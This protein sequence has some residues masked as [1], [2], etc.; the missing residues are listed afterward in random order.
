MVG[1]VVS[2]SSQAGVTI[3][4]GGLYASGQK[5]K[6]V[7]AYWEEGDEVCTIISNTSSTLYFTSG[8]SSAPD[9]GD[10]IMVGRIYSQLK[11]QEYR[12]GKQTEYQQDLLL[13][14]DFSAL[15]SAKTLIVKMYKD[16]SDTASTWTAFT[17]VAGVTFQS[18]ESEVLVDLSKSDGHV[19]I[20]LYTDFHRSV[21]FEF[22]V[23]EPN[24]PLE[25]IRYELLARSEPLRGF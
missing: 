24:V 7:A 21:T 20:P 8:Y 2:G 11:T 10:T 4:G 22:I 13:S 15:S 16:G 3:S 23:D 25:L 12:V 5:L 17:N 19:E 9:A 14:M 1:T 18:G 6:G